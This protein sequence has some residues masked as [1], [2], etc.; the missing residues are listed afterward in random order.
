M[1][2]S[3]NGKKRTELGRSLI[4]S[5]LT[6]GQILHLAR[7]L[8][9][10]F[11]NIKS[12]DVPYTLARFLIV[13]MESA[14]VAREVVCMNVAV[15]VHRKVV[16]QA[17]QFVLGGCVLLD[18]LQIDWLVPLRPSGGGASQV[19]IPYYIHILVCAPNVVMPIRQ[20]K[21]VESD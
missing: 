2:I 6:A 4:S 12:V 9:I 3:K 16:V 8:A 18:G 15:S 11:V 14:P 20:L 13:T 5:V 21:G 1:N 17:I 10:R 19:V 7:N